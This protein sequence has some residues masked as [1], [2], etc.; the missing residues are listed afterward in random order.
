VSSPGRVIRRAAVAIGIAVLAVQVGLVA[1][2]H[3][4]PTRYFAWA[5]NDYVVQYRLTATVDGHRLSD[6][7]VR[8]RYHLAPHGIWYFPAQHLVDDV[9][10]YE[11]TYGARDRV[12]VTLTYR[13]NGHAEQTWR[14]SHG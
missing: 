9:Q 12:R 1:Y 8:S 11:R 2:E 10:Q 4:G 13:L 7:G 14:W 6:A 3:L 5:P